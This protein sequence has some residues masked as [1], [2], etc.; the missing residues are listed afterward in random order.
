[1]T[2][3]MLVGK[4]RRIVDALEKLLDSAAEKQRGLHEI[5]R[6]SIDFILEAIDG[7]AEVRDEYRDS[8]RR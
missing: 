8:R 3:S 5:E 2:D 4:V 6:P 7:L 1:M